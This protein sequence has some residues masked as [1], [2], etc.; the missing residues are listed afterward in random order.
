M[1]RHSTT[2]SRVCNPVRYGRPASLLRRIGACLS[3]L[4]LAACGGGPGDPVIVPPAGPAVPAFGA[5]TLATDI[6]AD[7]LRE[8]T[9]TSAKLR[10]VADNAGG[11]LAYATTLNRASSPLSGQTVLRRFTPST[12]WG[13][14]VYN[15]VTGAIDAT[16]D[17]LPFRDPLKQDGVML[18]TRT[19]DGTQTAAIYDGSR[20]TVLD[21]LAG[22]SV[23]HAFTI[24]GD[25][26]LLRS[27]T[28][29]EPSLRVEV[30]KFSNG[31][32][33]SYKQFPINVA[34]TTAADTVGSVS[35]YEYRDG[36]FAEMV[37]TR[38]SD[39]QGLYP[40]GSG[41]YT[42]LSGAS[43]NGSTLSGARPDQTY[44]TPLG[45]AGQRRLREITA[46][47][48]GGLAFLCCTQPF[49]VAYT[50]I[51]G[52]WV[53]SNIALNSSSSDYHA[54]TTQGDLIAYAYPKRETAGTEGVNLFEGS[55]VVN[56]RR[57]SDGSQRAATGRWGGPISQSAQFAVMRDYA[58]TSMTTWSV[59]ERLGSALYLERPDFDSGDYRYAYAFESGNAQYAVAEKGVGFSANDP[60]M[61][62]V[63]WR[64]R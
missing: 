31:A 58:N 10:Y 48:N 42:Q 25:G 33:Q 51:G 61:V 20:I 55:T 63:K 50:R 44:C 45:L 22:S 21:V 17:V 11:L 16:V 12:G 46:L 43:A 36:V 37:V 4:T 39:T 32:W 23:D 28:V 15:V 54:Y 8:T 60:Q 53:E 14:P 34:G 18:V 5:W 56:L 62:R 41:S 35:V 24:S 52:A 47:A 26:S 7:S 3:L 2:S 19:A 6:A 1:P 30:S 40:C 29:R 64:S 49:P 57:E 38:P 27:R 59:Y 9:D 13:A